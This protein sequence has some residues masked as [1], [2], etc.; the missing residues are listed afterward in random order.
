MDEIPK[1]LKLNGV[2]VPTLD[3]EKTKAIAGL[4][5]G[6]TPVDEKKSDALRYC[7]MA[8]HSIIRQ[9]RQHYGMSPEVA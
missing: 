3:Y 9:V 4:L 6:L 2:N 1:T 8:A 7:T 5:F